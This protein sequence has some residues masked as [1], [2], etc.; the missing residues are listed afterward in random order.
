MAVQACDWA[1]EGLN[2]I[3]R[4]LVQCPNRHVAALQAGDNYVVGHLGHG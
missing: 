2:W 1:A 3:E 4:I